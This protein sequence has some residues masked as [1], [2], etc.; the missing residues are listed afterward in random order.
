[1]GDWNRR[2]RRDY[3]AHRVLRSIFT[4]VDSSSWYEHRH[5]R[6]VGDGLTHCLRQNVVEGSAELRNALLVLALD[7]GVVCQ[8]HHE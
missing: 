4:T 8:M 1:M 3:K 2:G 5:V 6:M 7:G